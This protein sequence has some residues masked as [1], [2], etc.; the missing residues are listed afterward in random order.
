VIKESDNELMYQVHGGQL[1]SLG[2]L[3]DRYQSQ[4]F[5]F[6]TGMTQDRELSADLVQN[7]FYRILKYRSQFRGGSFKIWMF[8]IA[9]NVLNDQYKRKHKTVSS[10]L[11]DFKDHV[12]DEKYADDDLHRREDIYQLNKALAALSDEKREILLLSKYQDKNYKEIAEILGTTEGN[13]KVKVFRALNDLR[14]LYHQV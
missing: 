1:D 13:V 14:S 8:H 12:K 11:D 3:Y 2:L 5:G 10:S 4:L 7:V 9:R 6:F